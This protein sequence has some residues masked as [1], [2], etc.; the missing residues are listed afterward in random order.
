MSSNK[1]HPILDPS[2]CKELKER[3]DA[4]F[5]KWYAN[6]FLKGNTELECQ[7]EWEEY[8]V[9]VKDKLKIWNLVHV[10]NK[11]NED[12]KENNSNNSSKK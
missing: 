3:H 12:K 1:P 10:V 8:Q 11:E 4:C 9:C 2:L 7:D 6:V 5:N